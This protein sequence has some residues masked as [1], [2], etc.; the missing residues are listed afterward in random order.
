MNIKQQSLVLFGCLLLASSAA[1]TQFTWT[2]NNGMITITEYHSTA[3]V[4]TIPSSINNLPVT[5]I[6]TNA[7]RSAN[8]SSV[9]IP[10]S[11]TSIEDS[12][13][14]GCTSLTNIAIPDS[15]ASIAF[16]AFASCHGL[17][18]ITIPESV[19]SIGED[20]FI[21]CKNLGN[22]FFLG[23]APSADPTAFGEGTFAGVDPATVYYLPGTIGWSNRF[24]GLST[25]RW[26]PQLQ[27]SDSSFGVK[28]NQFRFN[29]S[30]ASGMSF[31][32]EAST[33]LANPTWFPVVTNVLVNGLFYFSDSQ[34]T[35]YPSRFYRIR[36]P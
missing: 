31:V 2:T 23:N 6:G 30:W 10:D 13:F 3:D 25:A 21:D 24:A 34:W 27:T 14:Y 32:V 4:V 15:I 11:V 7:F 12:A 36:S 8:V 1:Q 9:T 29:V 22:M 18:S 33:D 5:A 28:T 26:T 19:I 16:G 17:T 20:A 35:N